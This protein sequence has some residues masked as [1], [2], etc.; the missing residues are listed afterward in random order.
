M[1]YIN[2]A[3]ILLMVVVFF[4]RCS[5]NETLQPNSGYS[6]ESGLP[7]WLQNLKKAP[8]TPASIVTSGGYASTGNLN[9]FDSKKINGTTPPGT[10]GSLPPGSFNI[11]RKVVPEADGNNIN[12]GYL[13]YK[14]VAEAEQFAISPEWA[15]CIYLGSILNGASIKG[16]KFSPQPVQGIDSHLKPITV[17]TTL[18]VS[19]GATASSYNMMPVSDL[20]F[21]RKALS[22]YDTQYPGKVGT[23]QQM[24]IAIDTFHYFNE[25]QKSYGYNKNTNA[26]FV[27]ASSKTTD[28]QL[29]ISS[30]SGAI[31]RFYTINF[32]M[33]MDIPN[34]NGN[35]F[36]QLIDPTGLDTANIFGGYVP[37]YV[38]S[39]SYGRMGIMVLQSD[40]S[41]EDLY[42]AVSKQVNILSGLVG[43][44]SELTQSEKD[45]LNSSK[46]C[47]Q[48]MGPTA[49]TKAL[50]V[51][52]L[53]GMLTVLEQ[54]ATYSKTNPGIPIFFSLSY[55][56]DASNVKC[57]FDI[58]WPFLVPYARM[59]YKNV[60]EKVGNPRIT[61][62]EIGI[63]FYM[64]DLCK[65]PYMN[66]PSFL[67]FH[68]NTGR[69]TTSYN[70][71]IPTTTRSTTESSISNSNN[72]SYTLLPG[73]SV[74]HYKVY[75]GEVGTA[76]NSSEDTY[77]YE[78]L[79]N[80]GYFVKPRS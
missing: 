71:Y 31:I 73:A 68:Y 21:V 28:G 14:Q 18:A 29:E 62:A 37:Y 16:N 12:N 42:H 80:K 49:S 66:C 39:I 11:V 41:S 61:S 44:G 3:F 77:D 40:A 57:T 79:Q 26:I 24:S 25:L 13:I 8:I 60:T 5:K 50:P 58:N 45:I 32:R 6:T 65:I 55:L 4:V 47:Y 67:E 72:G 27:D 74:L 46:I 43:A 34:N 52:G 30:R 63:H 20:I 38:S 9:L 2:S 54:S 23:A 59:E 35:V 76:P 22:D 56:N 70:N 64:D 15:S 75:Y 17:S 7:N 1:K 36:N 53:N 19:P 51:T 48:L 10:K 33:D 69:V 78:L